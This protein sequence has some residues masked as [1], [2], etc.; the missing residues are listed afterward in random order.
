MTGTQCSCGFTEL[1]DETL[2]DHFQQVFEPDDRR[3][4]DGREHVE[5]NPLTCACGFAAVTSAALDGH[6]L[7]VFAPPG[8]IGRDGK[9]HEPV[10]ASHGG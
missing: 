3:G 1:T 5:T 10:Q 4:A 6:F 7:K 9:R 8:A 2:T